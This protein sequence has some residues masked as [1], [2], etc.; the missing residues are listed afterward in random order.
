MVAVNLQTIRHTAVRMGIGIRAVPT[1]PFYSRLLDNAHTLLCLPFAT[2]ERAT[3][4]HEYRAV[5]AVFMRDRDTG[6]R[7][8]AKGTFE[9][10]CGI[11]SRHPMSHRAVV[12]TTVPFDKHPFC[13]FRFPCRALTNATR[14]NLPDEEIVILSKRF[15][16]IY[17]LVGLESSSWFCLSS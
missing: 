11:R 1:V 3:P 5:F 2:F 13:S 16:S 17:Q 7:R 12:T 6:Q 14:V 15:S 10:I 9:R 4:I 8:R